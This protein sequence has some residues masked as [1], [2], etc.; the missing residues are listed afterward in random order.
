MFAGLRMDAAGLTGNELVAHLTQR[1]LYIVHVLEAVFRV[2]AQAT[3][4]DSLQVVR[5]TLHYGAERWWIV[6]Q[7]GGQSSHARAAL[8]HPLSGYHFV[9]QRAEGK[10]VRAVVDR[11]ALG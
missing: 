4:D 2:L 6:P 8:K 5:S 9:K 7:N 10:N 1:H 3:G 11:P